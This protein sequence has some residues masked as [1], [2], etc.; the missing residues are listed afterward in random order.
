MIKKLFAILLHPVLLTCLGLL[1][2]GLLIWWIGPLIAIGSIYPL[3]SE[4][5]RWVTIGGFVLLAVLRFALSRWQQRRAARRLADGMVQ[6]SVGA[7]DPKGERPGISPETQVLN[8]RF[9]DA[10][11]ALRKMRT[12]AAGGK[13]G[14][15]DWL[16]LSSKDFLYELPWYVFIGGPGS[17]K[18]TALTNSGLRFPLADKTGSGSI[19]GVGGTRNCDWWFTDEAVLIDTAGRYTT[20]DSHAE[21]DK[22]AWQGFLGLLK[23]TRP[24]RPLNGI[25]L[26]VSVPDLLGQSQQERIRLAE[27]LR[28]RL[29][30]IDN[31]LRIR[32][33]IYVLVTKCDLLYGFTEYFDDLGKEAR[34]Q[35]WGA[36][37]PLTS[38]SK[39]QPTQE[40][41]TQLQDEIALLARRL[42][43]GLIDRLQQESDAVRRSAIFGFPTQFA[44]FAPLLGEFLSE[45]FVASK[46]VQSP[47]VRGVYFTSGTQE[48]HP[49]DRIMSGLARS[50]GL[51]RAPTLALARSGKSYFLLRLLRE[52]VFP[53]QGLAG[54]DLAWQRRS[55]WLRRGSFALMA[56]V[57]IGLIS[58]WSLSYINNSRYLDNVRNQTSQLN[59]LLAQ[60]PTQ[61]TAQSANSLVTLATALQA[62]RNA[63]ITGD[64]PEGKPALSMGWGL[65][66]GDKLDTAAAIANQRGL[67]EIFMPR[68]AIRIE[69]QLRGADP[70]NLEY[71]YEA[72]KA[73]L[74]LHDAERYDADALKTWIKIDWRTLDRAIDE[75]QR[76]ILDAQLDALLGKNPVQSTLPKDEALIE[77]VRA[78]LAR[79]PLEQR[80]YSRIRRQ[81]LT[82][83]DLPE[84]T[85]AKAAGPSAS[86]V[87]ERVSGKPLN[88]AVPALY[89]RDGY[90][91]GFNAEVVRVTALLS[92][93]ENWVMG[94]SPKTADKAK[95]A[96]A[97]G[98]VTD[99][100]KQLYLNDYVKTWDA[101]LADVR[102]IKTS[103]LEK[104]IQLARILSGTDSPLANFLRAVVAE[105][106]LIR[107]DGEKSVA[108]KA[109]DKVHS[110]RSELEKILGASQPQV[111]GGKRIES[112]VD[113]HFDALRRLV[114]SPAPNQPA[115]IDTSLKLFNDVYVYLA[116]VDVAT[117]SRSA[118]P[119]ATDAV[120]IK[121]EAQRLPEPV[122][123]ML[124]GISQ[125]GN[126]QT[127]YA[128]LDNLQ[129]DLRPITE[130]CKQAIAGRYPIQADS[131]HDILPEDFARLFAPGGLMDDFFNKRLAALVDTSR[132]PWCFKPTSDTPARNSPA[133]AQFE[134]AAKIKEAFFRSGGQTASFRLDFKPVEMDASI[135]QFILSVDGQL[136][137]Y[138]HGPVVP[139]SVQ[140]PGQKGS[141]QVRLE[142]SPPSA[143]GNSGMVI[144]GPWALFRLFD[145]NKLEAAGAPERF[146]VV[147]GLDSRQARFEVTANSVQN[148]F[149]LNA[150]RSFSC[151]EGL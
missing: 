150:L 61:A 39:A 101:L 49:I 50:F 25:F 108:E 103:D 129:Q 37:L 38:S 2:L 35:V 128:E 88:A 151:P 145:R 45:V 149:R 135:S 20:Q 74:M 119:P 69:E 1:I 148:P 146:I 62:V 47:I 99:R 117:K 122:R 43:D 115:P 140:W 71:S 16:S 147:F 73:Y 12:T 81:G 90:T 143:S 98:G 31:G 139:M 116:A 126:K 32:L 85:V 124:E 3:T 91:Q 136:V 46:F 92:S 29:L 132:S 59:D 48:G 60:L 125:S 102:L 76:Q 40:L 144:D 63:W 123:S 142:L 23:K 134:R 19:Q 27:A 34:G 30:E 52:V 83:S 141:M 22:E 107:P 66:Q 104:S 111:V 9:T 80:I 84:F 41:T 67:R 93:E 86:L 94:R 21:N 14:W 65:Y 28:A 56:L 42:N 78:T 96:L 54:A 137:K 4:F 105:V 18:T 7:P 55:H 6:T 17:G 114:R 77:S 10:V 75:K 138:A 13:S 110:A 97:L 70:T 58:V 24:R 53:E 8:E 82:L 89:T 133:L 64:N 33:P 57:G 87:F 100:V 131:R 113:D 106:T 79:Y 68:L 15:R 5:A 121:T 51:A 72:L 11:A 130:F 26:T 120:R 109:S 95:E 36:T 44:S 127:R 118:P 112:I